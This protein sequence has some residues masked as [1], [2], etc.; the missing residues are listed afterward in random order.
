MQ[1][2]YDN[3]LSLSP[4]IEL[5]NLEKNT[6]NIQWIVIIIIKRVKIE[7]PNSAPKCTHNVNRN[8]TK[9]WNIAIHNALH[10]NLDSPP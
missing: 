10:S 7:M 1:S 8:L 5:Q 6:A 3:L 9:M 2:Y 4:R